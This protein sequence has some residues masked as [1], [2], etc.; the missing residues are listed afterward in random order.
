MVT[1]PELSTIPA[2][3]KQRFYLYHLTFDKQWFEKELS[4]A[5][6]S[7]EIGRI[8]KQYGLK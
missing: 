2:T 4:M 3:L 8:I 6:A 5:E 7:A 1:K